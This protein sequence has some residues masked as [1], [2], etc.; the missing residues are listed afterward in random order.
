[1]KA[2]QEKMKNEVLAKDEVMLS[3]GWGK[4]LAR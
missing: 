4:Y 1:M 2:Y 3:V